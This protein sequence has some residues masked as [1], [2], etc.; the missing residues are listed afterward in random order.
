MITPTSRTK[1]HTLR[2]FH[3]THCTSVPTWVAL[4]QPLL[5]SIQGAV[6]TE[7]VPRHRIESRCFR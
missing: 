4:L 2:Q 6:L 1:R 7:H 5:L 3:N